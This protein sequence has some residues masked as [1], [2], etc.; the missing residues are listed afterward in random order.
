M[1]VRGKTRSRP[2]EESREGPCHERDSPE[3]LHKFVGAGRRVAT[4]NGKIAGPHGALE[5]ARQQAFQHFVEA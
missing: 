3:G 2:D 5:L 4:M 1:T